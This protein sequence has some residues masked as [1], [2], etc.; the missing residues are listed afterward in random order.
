MPMKSLVL[1]FILFISSNKILATVQTPDLLI[2]E[3][4]TLELREMS[5]FPLESLNL[6]FRPFNYTRQTAPNTSCWRGYQAIWRIINNEIY[7]E[8][9]QR[10]HGDDNNMR[11]ENLND[12][13]TKNQM[14]FIEKDGLVL[15]NWVNLNLYELK[16]LYSNTKNRKRMLS[17]NFFEKKNIEK[18]DCVLSIKNGKI[19]RNSLN[20]VLSNKI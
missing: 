13:F 11:T 15:A 20:K 9:I 10:C 3:N 12:F 8:K 16:N 4:D 1:V 14:D 17:D 5:N 19:E 7:L 2:I 6:N 18:A